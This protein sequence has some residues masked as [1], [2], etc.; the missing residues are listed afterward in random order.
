MA[1]WGAWDN[2]PLLVDLL[3]LAGWLYAI[4]IGPLRRRFAPGEP[5]PKREA[6]RFYLG[7]AAFYLA[8]A[9]P[10]E[11]IGRFYLFSAEMVEHLLLY[12]PAAGL[13]LSGLPA[14]LVDRWLEPPRRRR[15]ARA[16]LHPV[17]GGGIFILVSTGAYLPRP[18]E[19][20]LERESRMVLQH[21]VLFAA[22]LFLWWPVVSPSR[23][24]PRLRF[25]PRMAYLGAVE[26]SLTAVF[27]LLIMPQNS[28]YPTYDFAPRLI[29][30]LSAVNDQ[31]LAG[32]LLAVVSSLVL[33]GALACAWFAWAR[34]EHA[35][36]PR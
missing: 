1:D 34:Q 12:F 17:V 30:G 25:G 4:V 23:V 29:S 28:M 8:V 24:L 35:K 7:L 16:V 20:A 9:P 2:E 11:R 32:V 14:W 22:G 31:V 18:Y 15:I 10:W 13:M 33:V 5:W 3:V 36:E 26:V 27:L 19:W 6:V 21:L